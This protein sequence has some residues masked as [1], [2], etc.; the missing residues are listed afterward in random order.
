MGL[1]S[2]LC[3]VKDLPITGNNANVNV[4]D[5][6]LPDSDDDATAKDAIMDE[7][8]GIPFGFTTTNSLFL[9][10]YDKDCSIMD[11]NGCGSARVYVYPAGVTHVSNILPFWQERRFGDR[12]RIKWTMLRTQ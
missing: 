1:C 2:N 9:L 8:V 4:D 6:V 10:D 3:A 12:R 7:A 11:V 5:N